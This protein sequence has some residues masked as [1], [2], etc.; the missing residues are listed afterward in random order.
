MS[1]ISEMLVLD[2]PSAGLS[3]IMAAELGELMLFLK[4]AFQITTLVVTHE[5]RSAFRIADQIAMLFN[6]SLL[7]VGTKKEIRAKQHPRVRQFLHRVPGNP[8]HTR[9]LASYLEPD[10]Q[11]QEAEP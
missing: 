9:A 10:L 4:E 6:G 2:E 1:L 11:I 3:R 8:V 5:L 7:A